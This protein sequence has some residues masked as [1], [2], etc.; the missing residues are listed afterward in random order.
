MNGAGL[1][2]KII[3]NSVGIFNDSVSMNSNF[4]ELCWDEHYFLRIFQG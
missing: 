1:N 2:S 3:V 4:M